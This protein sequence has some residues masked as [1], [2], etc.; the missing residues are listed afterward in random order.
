MLIPEFID[1]LVANR[2]AGRFNQPGIHGNA[3]VDGQPSAFELT[4][5]LG[6]LP[7]YKYQ[8]CNGVNLI[9]GVF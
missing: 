1:L 8:I 2:S 5:D 4:Q 9:D 7:R 6:G 3:F